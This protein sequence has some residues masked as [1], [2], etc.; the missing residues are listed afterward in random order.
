MLGLLQSVQ[1]SVTRALT[2]HTA[3]RLIQPWLW[4]VVVCVCVCVCLCVCVRVCVCARACVCVCVCVCVRM[5]VCVCM[6][7]YVCARVRVCVRA[8]ARVCVCVCTWMRRINRTYLPNV[9]LSGHLCFIRTSA[10][11]SINASMWGLK[12]VRND[13]YMSNEGMSVTHYKS[14][15]PMSG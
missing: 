13:V 3:Q 7:V 15:N 10:K 8:R 5:C 4:L 11:S 2:E 9:T 12:M 6:C 14:R 1:R